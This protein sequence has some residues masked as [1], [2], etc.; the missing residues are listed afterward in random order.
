M[1][2]VEWE[3]G[4]ERNWRQGAQ[5][6]YAL[7]AV[8]FSEPFIC[9]FVGRHVNLVCL[10]HYFLTRADGKIG[11][12]ILTRFG[13][14]NH[15]L[16][17]GDIFCVRIELNTFDVAYLTWLDCILPLHTLKC[18][19]WGWLWNGYICARSKQSTQHTQQN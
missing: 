12:N 19:C 4:R 18:W 3:W 10:V 9:S 2:E 8:L 1:H 5:Q 14:R 16:S 6:W 11:R 17:Q 7:D 13:F 15:V